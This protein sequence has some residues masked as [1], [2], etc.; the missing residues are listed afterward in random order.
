MSDF[1]Q[2]GSAGIADLV[3]AT[4]GQALNTGA[5][6]QAFNALATSIS[7]TT[8]LKGFGGSIAFN[9]SGG[10]TTYIISD[11][12]IS[13]TNI[14]FMQPTTQHAFNIYPFLTITKA[15]G[16]ITITYPNNSNTDCNFDYIVFLF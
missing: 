3:N 7:Q 4:K 14:I 15:S 10:Q 8:G 12:R 5:L 2:P 9:M 13:T 16:S 11:T 1:T 6:V